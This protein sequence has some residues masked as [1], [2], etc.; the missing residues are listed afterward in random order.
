[1]CLWTSVTDEANVISY[2][3]TMKKGPPS[4]EAKP[5]LTQA[6]VQTSEFACCVGKCQYVIREESECRRPPEVK[7]E[8]VESMKE[9]VYQVTVVDTP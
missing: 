2:W 5:G 9:N 1:M 7:H 4:S 8:K 6:W 3:G